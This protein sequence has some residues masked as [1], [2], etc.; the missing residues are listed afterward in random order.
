[1]KFGKSKDTRNI[2]ITT[3]KDDKQNGTPHRKVK[4]AKK[5]SNTIPRLQNGFTPKC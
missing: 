5:M 3:Q 2:G 4:K 1:L